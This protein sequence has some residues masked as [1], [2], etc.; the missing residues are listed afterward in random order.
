MPE[1]VLVTN[2]TGKAGRECCRALSDAGYTVFGTTR[3]EHSGK[4]LTNIGVTPVVCDYTKEM[5]KALQVSGAKLLLFITDFFKAAKNNADTEEAHGKH[6]VDA[7]KAAG[8]QH[9]IFVSVADAEKFPRACTHLL[10]KPRIEAY[11]RASG[12]P[13]SILRPGTFF[14]NFDDAANFNPLKKGKLFFLMTEKAKFCATYDIG[15]AAAVQFRAPDKWLGKSLDVIGWVGDL[16]A[17]GAAL[18]RVGGFPV[19]TGLAMPKFAR[20]LFLRDLDAMCEFFVSPGIASN[21]SDFKKHVP[22]ALDAEGWFRHHNQYNNGEPIVGNTS[23]PSSHH[24]LAYMAAVAAVGVA[25]YFGTR[26]IN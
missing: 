20:R 23:P 16:A 18:E 17:A 25:V 26:S 3:S 7:A 8:I 6:A 14:E 9:T 21:P 12:I 4:S 11:L 15:R 13:H 1:K 10:A 2:A 22:D 19:K 24:A 5:P